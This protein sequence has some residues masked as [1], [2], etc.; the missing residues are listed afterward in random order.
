MSDY[1]FDI[2]KFLE[3]NENK[4]IIIL[5]DIENNL[6]EILNETYLT[7]NFEKSDDNLDDN[8]VEIV[9]KKIVSNAKNFIIFFL[10]KLLIR[11]KN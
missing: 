2:N 8:Y 4:Q 10:W 11:L 3:E 7:F 1:E 6:E 9:I 5:L